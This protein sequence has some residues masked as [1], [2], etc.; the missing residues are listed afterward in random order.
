M[1]ITP[2]S[3]S[4]SQQAPSVPKKYNRTWKIATRLNGDFLT[5]L[6]GFI[7]SIVITELYELFKYVIESEIE[8][9]LMLLSVAFIS[10]STFFL[11][12]LTLTLASLQKKL[13]PFATLTAKTSYV[14]DN[15]DKTLP[16]LQKI[17]SCVFWSIITTVL[18]ASI[19][20][21]KFIWINFLV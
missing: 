15:W 6:S 3:I 5:F 19:N 14:V 20:I 18:Y 11:I 16:F 9:L 12:K 7:S 8:F 13:S 17:R 21:F 1:T 2:S 4:S 10:A